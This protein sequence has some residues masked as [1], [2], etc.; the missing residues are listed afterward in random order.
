MRG[1]CSCRDIVR[2]PAV[3]VWAVDAG[4]LASGTPRRCRNA[5]SQNGSP[6][7]LINAVERESPDAD[8]AVP[9]AIKCDRPGAQPPSDAAIFAAVDK[10][11]LN[12][13]GRLVMARYGDDVARYCRSL[14]RND[15][16][17]Q[18]AWECIFIKAIENLAG[19]RRE[20]SLKTWIFRIAHNHCIGLVRARERAARVH[21][22]LMSEPRGAGET[23]LC[24]ALHAKRLRRAL[25]ACLD[26]TS[27][28][29]LNALLLH[30]QQS[31]SFD[32]IALALEGK[33]ETW[34]K[35]VQRALP[36]LRDCILKKTGGGL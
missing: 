7:R 8:E 35:R 13:A 24:D 18:D 20:A 33:P 2:A 14:L 32:E 27:H 21:A 36:K 29:T 28:E 16:D 17:S 3:L 9:S 15:A 23:M 5:L 10:N 6:W 22:R 34:R 31:M 26:S 30:Y 12:L 25:Q 4:L 19:F 11:D 1:S